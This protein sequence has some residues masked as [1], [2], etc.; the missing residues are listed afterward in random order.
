[1][2]GKAPFRTSPLRDAG[3]GTGGIDAEDLLAHE[4]WSAP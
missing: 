4:S 2:F 3:F 1:M